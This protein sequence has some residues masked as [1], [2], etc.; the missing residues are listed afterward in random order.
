MTKIKRDQL[1][2]HL[3]EKQFNYLE[4]TLLDAIFTKNWRENW[5]LSKKDH[6]NWKKYCLFTIKKTLKVNRNKAKTTFE[7]IKENFGLKIRN[8]DKRSGILSGISLS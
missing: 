5:V 8:D 3:I 7:Y 6:E 1:L 4:L 2:E